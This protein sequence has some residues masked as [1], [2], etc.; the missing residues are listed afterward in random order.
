MS[1]KG[2]SIKIEQDALEDVFKDLDIIKKDL[3]LIKHQL[4]MLVKEEQEF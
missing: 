3:K 1:S 4:K 2:N